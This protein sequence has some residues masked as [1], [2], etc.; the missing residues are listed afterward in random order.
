MNFHT[1]KFTE[2]IHYYQK[3]FKNIPIFNRMMEDSCIWAILQHYGINTVIKNVYEKSLFK[4]TIIIIKIFI[5]QS[6]SYLIYLIL[7]LLKQ[8]K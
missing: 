2:N 3:I 6:L 4:I 5:I 8:T 7:Q 1:L